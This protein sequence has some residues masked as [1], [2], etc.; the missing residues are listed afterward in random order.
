M[1]PVFIAL[2]FYYSPEREWLRYAALAVYGL[3][4]LSDLVDGIIARKFN[5]QTKL[6]ARLDPLADKLLINLGFVFVT[7][8]PH[9]NPEIPMWFAAVI[10]I[11][12][13]ILV[14]SAYLINKR[15]QQNIE[16][17]ARLLGKLTAV[18]QM[19]ALIAVLACLPLTNLLLI[20]TLVLTLLSFIEYT[21][22]GLRQAW[23]APA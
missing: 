13:A 22:L 14:I 1:A 20:A 6:G 10:L 11:R 17:K 21:Y 8:N 15:I 2:I 23:Q 4:A 12:D 5:Q 19:A 9:F 3:A 18:F 16:I 7:A